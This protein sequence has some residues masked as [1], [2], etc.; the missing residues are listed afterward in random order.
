MNFLFCFLA[1]VGTVVGSGFVSGKEVV[2]FFTRFGVWSFPCIVLTFF[3]FFFLF[4]FLLNQGDKLLERFEKSKVS[5][6]LNLILCTIFSASM[7]AGAIDMLKGCHVIIATI[8]LG[9]IL[10]I[11]ARISKKGIS[12]L[13]KL[14]FLFVPL[15]T[16]LLIVALIIQLCKGNF[17]FALQTD[18]GGLSIVYTLFYVVLN[19]ANGGVIIAK[20]GKNL[21]SKQKSRVAFLSALVLCM[22]LTIINIVLLANPSV[23]S[24]EMPLLELFSGTF[25]QVLSFAIMIGCLTTLFSLIYSCSSSIR[26][27]CKNEI[28]IF[29]ISVFLPF[30]L[31]LSGFGFIISYLYPLGSIVA[32]FILIDLAFVPSLKRAYKKIHACRKNAK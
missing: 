13:N 31:S 27:L 3:L 23:L 4:K 9:A 24:E 1:I 26:G 25:R 12:S 32:I 17:A 2:V 10:L 7:F 15:M 6:M 19:T 29:F 14:N 16:I 22:I 8:I 28:M 5:L 20:L 18:F 30:I 21:S 11:G